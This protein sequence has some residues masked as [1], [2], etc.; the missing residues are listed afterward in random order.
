MYI[1]CNMC[2]RLE[3]TR[4]TLLIACFFTAI[5]AL[6]CLIASDYGISWDEKAMVIL[7]HQAYA[8]MS[9]G[10]PYPESLGIRF[11]GSFIEILLYAFPQTLGLRYARHIFILRHA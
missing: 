11:H 10:S 3:A 2:K 1:L 6:G 5:A 9:N 8:F 7:G 4:G